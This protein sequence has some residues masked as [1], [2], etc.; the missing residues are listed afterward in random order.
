LDRETCSHGFEIPV[1]G[2][3]EATVH[4]SKYWFQK[5]CTGFPPGN[6]KWPDPF[7]GAYEYTLLQGRYFSFHLSGMDQG[8]FCYIFY[9]DAQII[10]IISPLWGHMT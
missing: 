4:G 1:T 3:P 2:L 8:Y 5:V 6:N 10:Y 9:N 7:G